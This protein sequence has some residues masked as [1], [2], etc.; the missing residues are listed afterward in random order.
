ME[1]LVDQLA[2]LA[3]PHRL[4]V[5][6]LLVR[7]CPDFVP[8]GDIAA[9]L[10][11]KASTSSAHLAALTRA[12]LIT[13]HRIGTSIRYQYA[14]DGSQ[15]MLDSLFA[16]CCRGRP[17]LCPTGT[18]AAPAPSPSGQNG[19]Y[20][21]LFVCTGN[22][23]RSIMAEALLNHIAPERFTAYSAGTAPASSPNLR[24]LSL[25]KD[26]GLNTEALSSKHIADLRTDDAPKMDFVFTVCD[27][28]ANEDCPT[29]PGTPVSGH[30]GLPDPVKA[31]GSDAEKRLAFQQTYGALRNRITAFAALPIPTLD[32]IALQTHVDAIALKET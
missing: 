3:H 1:I 5:F 8:A 19:T 13:Q 28:A 27:L 9:A 2:A 7:R 25:L 4:A 22:S 32:R 16:E 6:R 23:A 24:T 14:P 29:W 31:T 17:E 15:Q 26:K 10:D 20:N 12:G 21:V 11:L 30:W 18:E